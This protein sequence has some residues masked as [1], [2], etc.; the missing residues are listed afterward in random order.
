LVH[1]DGEHSYAETYSAAVWAMQHTDFILAHDTH[2][3][4]VEVTPALG[5]AACQFGFKFYNFEE[6]EGLGILTTRELKK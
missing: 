2:N 6:N 3:Q 5:A 4:F 1:I